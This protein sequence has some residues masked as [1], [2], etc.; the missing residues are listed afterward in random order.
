MIIMKYF[1]PQVI[2]IIFFPFTQI[3]GE[4]ALKNATL[5]SLGLTGK[6]TIIR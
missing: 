1:Y 3:K 4:E 2:K 5:H 6:R